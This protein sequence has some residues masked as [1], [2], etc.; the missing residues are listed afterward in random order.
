MPL[1]ILD[2]ATDLVWHRHRSEALAC[3]FA[4]L[5]KAGEL[6]CALSAWDRRAP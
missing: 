2:A 1:A 5:A 3:A 6:N 4:P